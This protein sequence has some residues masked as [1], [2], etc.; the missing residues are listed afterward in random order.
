MRSA[1]SPVVDVG[2]L[3]LDGV[4]ISLE[5]LPRIR[6]HGRVD[7]PV[8]ARH[9]R[10]DGLFTV[11]DDAQR[12]RLHPSGAQAA[13][14]VL[15]QQR[16]DFVAD[17][18][19]E[20]TARLLRRHFVLVDATGILQRLGHAL[21]GDFVQQHAVHLVR[22]R[23]VQLAGNV[24]GNRLPFAVRVR[25][26]EHLGRL[27]GLRPQFPQHLLLAL[28]GDVLRGEITCRVD[29]QAPLRQV[30]HVAHRSLH[31]VVRTQIFLDR[32]GFR[33]RLNNNQGFC[34]DRSSLPGAGGLLRS[35][36]QLRAKNLPGN[37]RTMPRNSRVANI[38]ATTWAGNW[39]A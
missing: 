15:P 16:A 9:E 5:R 29:A 8:F 12:Y 14:N 6:R 21:A 32:P 3:A 17:Q 31:R 11:A 19:V 24:P 2:L 7:A 22:G 23:L 30:L 39:L 26:Q 27:F 20:Q 4:Q 38:L 33:R 18:P 1:S 35:Q 25:R 37:C 28:N 13:L 34:H 36:D 10:L